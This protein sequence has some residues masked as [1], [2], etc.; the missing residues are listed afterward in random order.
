MKIGDV[1]KFHI[2]RGFIT[3]DQVIESID[4]ASK[5][6]HHLHGAKGQMN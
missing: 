5:L 2:D 1:L 3:A 4:G 6:L